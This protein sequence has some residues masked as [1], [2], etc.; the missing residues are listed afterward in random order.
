MVTERMARSTSRAGATHQVG[1]PYHWGSRGLTAGGSANDL[2]PI[3]LDPNVHIARPRSRPA[4]SDREGRRAG[5]SHRDR[6]V[7]CCGEL[8]RARARARRVLHRHDGLHRLQGLRGRLQGVEPRAR[9][10]LRL[11]RRVVRQHRRAER[12]TPGGTSPSS[13]RNVRCACRLSRTATAHHP[14]RMLMSSDVCKHCTPCRLPRGLPDR[15]ALPHRVRDG[16]RAGRRLQRLRLLRARMPLRRARPPR[17][18]EEGRRRRRAGAQVHALLRPPRRRAHARRAPRRARPS[19]SSSAPLEF[20]RERGGRAPRDSQSRRATTA[21][22]CTERIPGTASEGSERSSCCST[23]RRSTGCPPDPGRSHAQARP[24]VAQRRQGR[25]P[26]SPRPS[27]S[28]PCG[29]PGD[30]RL[31]ATDPRR[32]QRRQLLLRTTDPQAARLEA[33]HR[34]VLLRRRPRGRIVAAGARRPRCAG[35]DVLARNCSLLAA[36]GSGRQ[37]TAC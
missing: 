36:C 3:V 21:P 9:R 26:R 13:S 19:R 18:P 1:L 10:R 27:R 22:A 20:L 12:R 7:R 37:P 32:P 6:S 33:L 28:P 2:L 11:E 24:D 34:L 5:M 14:F 16:R 35:N 29:G 15:R 31:H 8:R 23:S 25:A 30:D 17:A 4:T